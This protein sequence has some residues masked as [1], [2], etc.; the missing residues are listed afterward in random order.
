MQDLRSKLLSV[1]QTHVLKSRLLPLVDDELK[2]VDE[3]F[4]P[5]HMKLFYRNECL[6]TKSPENVD[7]SLQEICLKKEGFP[8]TIFITAETGM[9]K[10]MLCKK[11]ISSWCKTLKQGKERKGEQVKT[12]FLNSRDNKMFK[13]LKNSWKKVDMTLS[14]I[15]EKFVYV[16]FVELRYVKSEKTVEEMIINQLLNGEHI[17]EFR[18]AVEQTPNKC[19]YLIDGLDEWVPPEQ[20]SDASW[21]PE[22]K[23]PCVTLYTARPWKMA[24]ISKQLSKDHLEIKLKGLDSDLAQWMT[25]IVFCNTSKENK[26]ADFESAHVETYFDNVPMLWKFVVCYWQEFKKIPKSR[27]ELYAA[28]V[29]WNFSCAIHNEYLST[30]QTEIDE[31]C[32]LPELLSRRPIYSSVSAFVSKLASLC[33]HFLGQTLDFSDNDLKNHGM[34]SDEISICHKLGIQSHDVKEKMSISSIHRSFQDFFAAIYLSQHLDRLG[35]FLANRG[36][37]AKIDF[38]RKKLVLIFLSGLKSSSFND[39]MLGINELDKG[40]INDRA[41]I[42]QKKQLQHTTFSCIKE[43]QEMKPSSDNV[44]TVTLNSVLFTQPK[45][46]E[47]LRYLRPERIKKLF[48]N[49][50]EVENNYQ[51]LLQCS[52]LESLHVKKLPYRKWLGTNLD[53]RF[54]YNKTINDLLLKQSVLETLQIW[55]IVIFQSSLLFI[56]CKLTCLRNLKIV[57]VK[58]YKDK[59]QPRQGEEM[60]IGYVKN[61]SVWKSTGIIDV[62]SRAPSVEKLYLR[63]VDLIEYR[64]Y[65]QLMG[66]CKRFFAEDISNTEIKNKFNKAATLTC[67]MRFGSAFLSPGLVPDKSCMEYSLG[68]EDIDKSTPGKM[69]N[70]DMVFRIGYK[71]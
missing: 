46:I 24:A 21:L 31:D 15:M 30:S 16:F 38:D 70:I 13:D 61:L 60:T 42:R 41:V 1:F 35:E 43:V 40:S 71:S 51:K 23:F 29:E 53:N 27:T 63:Q 22:K 17:E 20:N 67:Q 7:E 54:L 34:S 25:Y 10:T 49:T 48:I 9:G 64:K 47:I 59:D 18:K 32:K 45:D 62:I 56:L 14:K 12:C 37:S 39:I 5:V 58:V 44:Q 28:L 6:E 2:E 50:D 26:I 3:L 65:E 4:V 55:D 68:R 36:Q 57:N 19:L 11:I 33:F 66:S 8:K 52:N 69:T